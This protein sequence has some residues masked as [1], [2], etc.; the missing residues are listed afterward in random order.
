MKE[1]IKKLIYSILQ[2]ESKIILARFKPYIIMVTGSVGKTSTK[3][4]L[5]S[6]LSP[7]TSV[8][9]SEKSFNSNIGVPLTILGLKNGWNNIFFWTWNIFLGAFKAMFQTRYPKV[10]ILEVGADKSGELEEILEDF[11]PDS[12]V[13]TLFPDVPP[14]V[15]NYSSREELFTAEALPAFAVPK[16]GFVILNIDDERVRSL[17]GEVKGQVLFYGATPPSLFRLVGEDIQYEKIAGQ[18]LPFGSIYQF[19]WEEENEKDEREKNKRVVREEIFLP[20]VLGIQHAYPISASLAMVSAFGFD[21][22][23][24]L[25]AFS[26]HIPPKGRMNL[27]EGVKGTMIIDDTYNSSPKAV[28]EALKTLKRVSTAGRR[29]AVLGDMLELGEYSREA[30]K[31]AGRLAKAYADILFTVGVH[32]RG[33]AEGALSSGMDEE[34][35]FQFDDS[36]EAGKFLEGMIQFGDAILVKG[37][38]GMRM[39][40][41]VLE[42]MRHPEQREKLLVRQE[43]EWGKR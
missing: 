29:I 14:H 8:R 39:E 23:K 10:L 38:Q 41:V 19:E 34:K 31:E 33:T 24:A 43:K 16:E 28:D 6:A 13:V 4:A 22:K 5:A 42:V 30:H 26:K 3:D 25:K 18:F 15:E 32:S 12:C 2:Y 20:R 1:I 11:E 9:K 37:S 21:P 27:I 17:E 40:R 7:F 35:I 36:R